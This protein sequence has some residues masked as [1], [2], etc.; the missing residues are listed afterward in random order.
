MLRHCRLVC[1]LAV[2]LIIGCGKSDSGQVTP[3]ASKP[4][5]PPDKVVVTVGGTAIRESDLNRG[6]S[7]NLFNVSQDDAKEYRLRR[8]VR[9]TFLRQFLAS[10]KITV[11]EETVEQKIAEYRENPPRSCS[12]CPPFKTLEEFLDQILYTL[13]EFKD[14]IR[15]QLGLEKYVNGLWDKESRGGG[16]SKE[17]FM[18]DRGSGVL[19]EIERQARAI[20]DE[21]DR[22]A[23]PSDVVA[24]KTE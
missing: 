22:K 11:P 10:H 17:E 6:T 24:S 18:D 9:A 1:V 20:L 2:G 8:I 3:H 4:A 5:A 12:C 15:N 7:A 23:A 14:D 19:D 21:R 13:P 16:V